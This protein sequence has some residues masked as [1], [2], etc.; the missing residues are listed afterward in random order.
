M[1]D[2]WTKGYVYEYLFIFNEKRFLHH[3][4]IR[5]QYKKNSIL[6]YTIKCI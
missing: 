5:K 4:L 6:S 2:E 1:R 3:I